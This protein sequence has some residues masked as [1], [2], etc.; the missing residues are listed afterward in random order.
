VDGTAEMDIT[1]SEEDI[2]FISGVDRIRW[3]LKR[4]RSHTGLQIDLHGLTLS[5]PRQGQGVPNKVRQGFAMRSHRMEEPH[6]PSIPVLKER[7]PSG[8]KGPA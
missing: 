6:S 4:G 7:L 2:R 1:F 5:S 3:A 8:S